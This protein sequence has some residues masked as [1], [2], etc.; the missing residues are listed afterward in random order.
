MQGLTTTGDHLGGGTMSA[1]VQQP[2]QVLNHFGHDRRLFGGL[3]LPDN[4][5]NFVC[6]RQGHA[7][8]VRQPLIVIIHI[9][10][11]LDRRLRAIT[12]KSPC[13]QTLCILTGLSRNTISP[14]QSYHCAPHIPS[15]LLV[16]RGFATTTVPTYPSGCFPMLRRNKPVPTRRQSNVHYSLLQVPTGDHSFSVVEDELLI[17]GI[18]KTQIAPVQF[19]MRLNDAL[20]PDQLCPSRL[21]KTPG[22]VDVCSLTISIQGPP[23]NRPGI[24]FQRPGQPSGYAPKPPRPAAPSRTSSS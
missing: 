22:T 14:V 1:A 13:R 4:I 18:L 19:G 3:N 23:G 10:G 17:P 9:D 7:I 12:T 5:R 6:F 8:T 11:R 16:N 15:A 2:A 24:L 20:G 21:M